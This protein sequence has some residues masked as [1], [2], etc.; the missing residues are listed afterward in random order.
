MPDISRCFGPMINSPL[1]FN[2]CSL[3]EQKSKAICKDVSPEEQNNPLI[4]GKINESAECT[5][6][7]TP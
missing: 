1:A 2:I 5:A 7:T 6:A 4:L 3:V